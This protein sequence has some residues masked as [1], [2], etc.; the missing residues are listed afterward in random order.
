MPP[1]SRALSQEHRQTARQFWRFCLTGC[2][3][4]TVQYGVFYSLYAL[5]SVHYVVASVL[6]C[7]LGSFVIFGINRHWT[8]DAAGP[9][10]AAQVL[11]FWTC[12]GLS[13]ALN[14]VSIWLFTERMRFRPEVS[15]V[16]TMG[17]TTV[18]NFVGSKFWV[19]RKPAPAP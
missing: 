13:F 11:K 12:M 17:V 9:A 8:F 18:F 6:G 10:I 3:G 1:L 14:A 19:F 7:I 5:A 15:Q 16:L 2:V 4:V